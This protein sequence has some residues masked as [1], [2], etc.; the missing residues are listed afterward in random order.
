MRGAVTSERLV[1]R[2]YELAELERALAD[3]GDGRPRVV[4]LAG[5]SGVGKTRLVGE[6]ERRAELAGVRTLRGECVEISDG[7]LPY[8]PLVAALRPLVRDGDPALAALSSDATAE[9]A[10][11][12]P[13]LDVGHPAMKPSQLRL[14]EALLELLDRLSSA[15]PLLL[16]IEDLHWADGSTRSFVTFLARTLRRERLALVLTY[17]SDELHRRHPMR[18]LIAELERGEHA[19][20]LAL[21][22]FTREELA[23]ALTDIV[24]APPDDELLERLYARAEGN[25]LYTEELLAAGLDGRGAA[26]RS[27]RDAFALRVERLSPAAQ[28]LLRTIAVAERADH[29]LLARVSGVDPDELHEVL[30]EAVSAQVVAV[31]DDGRYRLRHALLREIAYED[32]LPGERAEL[33]LAIGQALALRAQTEPRTTL[34]SAIAHHYLSASHWKLALGA[35]VRAAVAAGRVHAYPEAARLLER[36][37]ELWEMVPEAEELAGMDH[38]DLLV[39]AGRAHGLAGERLRSEHLLRA[40]LRELES[41]P[42]ADRSRLPDVLFQ[43]ARAEWVLNRGDDALACAHRALELLDYDATAERAELLGWLARVRSLRG[44]HHDAVIDARDALALARAAGDAEIE[45]QI[46]NTLALSLAGQGDVLEGIE[47]MQRALAIAR[48]AQNFDH[49]ANAYSNLGDLY[50]LA[51]KSAE[52]M[53]AVQEGLSVMPPTMRA[54][55]DWLRLSISEFAFNR[56]D[57]RTAAAHLLES[58]RNTVGRYLMYAGLRRAEQHLGEGDLELADTAIASVEPLVAESAEPQFHGSMG[59]LLAQLRRRRG[60]LA[61]AARAVDAALDQLEL[62]T[63][64]VVRIVRVAAEGATVAADTAQRARDLDERAAARARGGGGAWCTSAA[65]GRRR[66]WAARWSGR[67]RR[68]PRPSCRGRGGAAIRGAGRR[69]PP[70]GRRWSGRTA[71]RWH[72]G[73]W[74]RRSC[75]EAI[76]TRRVTRWPRAWRSRAGW[77]RHG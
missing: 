54:G 19:V 39:R 72:A 53:A 34:L 44:R 48:D 38:V 8:A 20:G 41:S 56:G 59:A 24:G 3:A 4:V 58:D 51:G 32:L 57:W 6:L 1:G 26:P 76:A 31:S 12:L 64:D 18:P 40:A 55:R 52:A 62:C 68:A 14:F 21:A 43:L 75:S 13:G 30:R 11:L 42:D 67:G 50:N 27:L 45:G 63:D 61:G 70:H 77:A 35:S 36:A 23:E 69:Q 71:S 73:G 37:M 9:L 65:C 29:D 17:R 60:D 5:D 15:A 74:A 66:A 10:A 2:S 16:A 49:M 47:T 28:R 33:H 25:P 46:L 22:P 7:E